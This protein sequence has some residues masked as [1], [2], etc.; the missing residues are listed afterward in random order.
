M[1]N[2]YV[3]SSVGASGDGT[4]GSPWK[5]FSNIVWGSVGAGDSLLLQRG[6]SWREQLT[7]LDSGTNGNPI[8][9]GA[10]GSGNYP[11]ITA[12]D[13]ISGWDTGGN[14]TQVGA[15]DVWYIGSI[16]TTKYRLWLDGTEYKHSETDATAVDITSR[17]YNDTAA[18]RLYV[19]ATSNPATFYSSIEDSGDQIGLYIHNDSYIT[20]D[21]L[22]IRGGWCGI[23]INSDSEDNTGIIIQDCTIGLYTGLYGCLIV[24][25]SGYTSDDGIIT[26]CTVDS[27][28]NLSYLTWASQF[29]D[30]L[31]IFG[32]NNWE[33]YNNSIYNWYHVYTS[34]ESKGPTITANNN[35]IHDNL[36]QRTS[37]NNKFGRG[38]STAGAEGECQYNK[39]YNNYLKDTSCRN[40]IAGNNNLIYYN[41]LDTI[42]ATPWAADSAQGISL[43]VLSNISLRNK[44]YNNVI[45]NTDDEGIRISIGGSNNADNEVVNNIILDCGAGNNDYGIK[46]YSAANPQVIKNNCIYSGVVTDL[47]DYRGTPNTIA[48]LNAQVTD[49]TS[50]NIQADPEFVSGG[51]TVLKGSP[52]NDAGLNVGLTTDYVGVAV[53]DPPTIGAY[54]VPTEIGN[55]WG[56]YSFVQKGSTDWD[57]DALLDTVTEISDTVTVNDKSSAVVSITATEGNVGAI[58][59][60]VTVYILGDIDGTNFEEPTI[61]NTYKVA[62]TPVQN[63]AVRIMIPIAPQLYKNFKVAVENQSGQELSMSVRI[64]TADR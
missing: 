58:D 60:L 27:G 12:R 7:V 26:G 63:D 37:S 6:E 64:I 2:Y 9:I 5:A 48:E 44:I 57:A 8:T 20:L 13:E 4:I 22:D 47:I 43:E 59:G 18:D 25:F 31:A 46:I 50:D 16:T 45:Y 34:M 55:D 32:G 15:T 61:G 53:L 62:F 56:D 21:N 39:I 28:I 35:K 11:I 52:C 3:D 51:F 30:G 40:Q 41:I 17:W 1:A 42:I 49:T 29:G 33:W 24:G 14:W 23:N 10:Y 38:F 54:E 19:Y 36:M